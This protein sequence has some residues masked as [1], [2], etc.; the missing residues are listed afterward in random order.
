MKDYQLITERIASGQM[1]P[2]L[3]RFVRTGLKYAKG[4][5]FASQHTAE[6]PILNLFRILFMA[7][8]RSMGGKLALQCLEDLR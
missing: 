8:Q 5:E 3:T 1:T 4:L 7:R 6:P 2:Q